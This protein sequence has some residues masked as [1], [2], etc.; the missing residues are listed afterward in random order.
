MNRLPTLDPVTCTITAEEAT[1]GNFQHPDPATVNSGTSITLE[2]ANTWLWSNT[3]SSTRAILCQNDG[4]WNPVSSVD[5]CSG[6]VFRV[7]NSF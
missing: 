5:T 3:Y 4:T 7:I 2:C 6:K 1:N